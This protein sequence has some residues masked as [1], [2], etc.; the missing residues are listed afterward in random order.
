[1]MDKV[2][3][4]CTLEYKISPNVIEVFSHANPSVIIYL[5]LHKVRLARLFDIDVQSI[6][7][8]RIR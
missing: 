5:L 2:N 1:M 4:S 3:C 6:I 8:S 7:F